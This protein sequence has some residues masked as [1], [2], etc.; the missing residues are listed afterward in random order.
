MVSIVNFFK[1][2]EWLLWITIQNTN[3]ICS[4]V[5]NWSY[6]FHSTIYNISYSNGLVSSCLSLDGYYY[7]YLYIFI[8]IACKICS[9]V[10]IWTSV[11]G[12][13]QFSKQRAESSRAAA[14][15]EQPIAGINL[16][17]GSLC[18]WWH[19]PADK[20]GSDTR[21]KWFILFL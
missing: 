4:S 14:R 21:G 12:T 1:M 10:Q 13:E 17:A 15:T 3:T 18:L 7:Y 5:V 9:N 16:E 11:F 20:P 6:M 8:F 2:F 19:A